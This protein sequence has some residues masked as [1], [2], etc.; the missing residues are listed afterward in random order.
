MMHTYVNNEM[1]H[2]ALQTIIFAIRALCS[3][4]DY[5]NEGFMRIFQINCVFGI[6]ILQIAQLTKI[7]N[8]IVFVV[9]IMYINCVFTYQFEKRFDLE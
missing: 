3:V 4:M 6:I 1:R 7:S 2:N 9:V 8:N 5:A